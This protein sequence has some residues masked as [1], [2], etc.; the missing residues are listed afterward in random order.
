[1]FSQ[2]QELKG[3]LQDWNNSYFKP[4]ILDLHTT[5]VLQYFME[6]MNYDMVF[7]YLFAFFLFLCF[8]LSNLMCIIL[9]LFFTLQISLKPLISI[10]VSG[11]TPTQHTWNNNRVVNNADK[12]DTPTVKV[13]CHCCYHCSFK[14]SNAS[15]SFALTLEQRYLREF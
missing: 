3:G 15:R 4:E 9:F 5:N 13:R 8:F 12:K 7:L 10:R 11:F 14:P 2:R 6:V 1:M